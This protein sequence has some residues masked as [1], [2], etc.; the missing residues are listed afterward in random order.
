MYNLT[1]GNY[2]LTLLVFSIAVNT[3]LIPFRIYQQKNQIRMASIRPKEMAIRKKYAG[4]T[5]AVTKQ[6]AQAEV[7][8]LY[9]R[10]NYSPLAGCLPLLIQMPIVIALFGIIRSPLTHIAELSRYV[11]DK[12]VVL[13]RS[14]P[15]SALYGAANYNN[16]A[17][18]VSALNNNDFLMQAQ[19]S[20]IQLPAGF[21]NVDLSLGGVDLTMSPSEAIGLGGFATVI[22]ILIPLLNF[23]AAF[24][25][26]RVTRRHMPQPGADVAGAGASM[27]MMEWMM[28]LM[29]VFMAYTFTASLGI[30]WIFQTVFA[31]A[32]TLILARI[33]PLPKFTE[34]D[35]RKAE[36]EYG[37]K[38]KKKKKKI[39]AIADT[40]EDGAED[41]VVAL[42]EIDV[43]DVSAKDGES[44]KQEDLAKGINPT[45]KTNYQ[46]TGKKYSVKKKK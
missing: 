1:N 26:M 38:K 30:Y 41:E 33:Y 16:Q 3:L 12:L 34:E 46:K 10:E 28:P 22:M 44:F 4:R 23:A 17:P 32:Q 25:Q 31:M 11:I 14:E 36:E 6:K 37:A 2:V 19:V 21:V 39:S 43:S 15:F 5:D 40:D 7:M 42:E 24:T 8:E 13:A 45:V 35:Y 9:K 29:F 27:K 18:L 20:N